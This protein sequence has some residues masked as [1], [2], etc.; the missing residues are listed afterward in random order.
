MQHKEIYQQSQANYSLGMS[1]S[2][3]ALYGSLHG[4]LAKRI[5]FRFKTVQA[6]ASVTSPKT[7]NHVVLQFPIHGH[8]PTF[9][10]L[11]HDAIYKPHDCT[12]LVNFVTTQAATYIFYVYK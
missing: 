7:I 3:F 10:A 12:I 8:V 4:H 2:I 11:S 9:F 5:S 1:K 6:C